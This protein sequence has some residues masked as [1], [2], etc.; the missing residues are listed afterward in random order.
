MNQGIIYAAI[1]LAAPDAFSTRSIAF[2]VA[3]LNHKIFNHPVKWQTII[4]AVLCMRHKI[5][6]RLWQQIRK[7]FDFNRAIVFHM[8]DNQFLALF[9][10]GKILDRSFLLAAASRQS[11]Q[12]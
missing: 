2:R 7:Y 4:I 11:L 1:K 6:A 9:R 12:K 5:L 8:D 10:G 3:A